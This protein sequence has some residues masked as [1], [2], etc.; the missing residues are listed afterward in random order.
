MEKKTH[1]YKIQLEYL[2]NNKG[3]IME[4]EPLTFEFQN[5][6]DIF[7]IIEMSIQ[8]NSFPAQQDN[9]EFA[10]GLKLFSEVMLRN[11]DNSLFED[12]I[13]VFQQ[14]MKKIKAK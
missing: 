12:F 5:H 11:K 1:Q 8:R 14:L 4:Q 13:P 7:K 10:L 6:D 3:E 2:K 9:I